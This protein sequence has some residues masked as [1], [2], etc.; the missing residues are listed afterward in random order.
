[1]VEALLQL[2]SPPGNEGDILTLEPHRGILGDLGAGLVHGMLAD[3]HL[4]GQNQRP[5]PLPGRD[6]STVDEQ[7]V[8]SDFLHGNREKTGK[9]CR[10]RAPATRSKE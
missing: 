4:A 3:H 7:F 2:Q 10:R 8:K 5:R 6:Q 1:M 9:S